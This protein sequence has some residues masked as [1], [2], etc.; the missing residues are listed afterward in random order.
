[1]ADLTLAGFVL[2]RLAEEQAVAEAA[3]PGPWE[4][5]VD[6][7]QRGVTEVGVWCESTGR[8]IAEQV[9]SGDR[10]AADGAHIARWDPARVLAEVEVK[11]QLLKLHAIVHREIGWLS[12]GEEEHAEIPVC[13]LCV[14]RHSHFRRRED[15]PEG[16]CSTV[17]LLAL[18]YAGHEA[19][20]VE[21][22]P[23]AP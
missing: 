20:R 15:V 1:M 9:T 7:H 17:R 5:C 11:R 12:D 8:Y 6:R 19:Y 16:A 10:A 3:S 14:P 18:P 22:A 2:A 4:A 21:W 13:G 23:D